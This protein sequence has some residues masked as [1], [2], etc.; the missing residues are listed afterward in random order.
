MILDTRGTFCPTPIIKVSEAVGNIDAG[1]VVELI[2]DDPAIEFDLPAWCKSAGCT[3]VS[4]SRK[5][6]DYRYC[7]RKTK[8]K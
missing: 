1:A 4:S 5:G 3:I 8:G 2:S 6:K 7:V